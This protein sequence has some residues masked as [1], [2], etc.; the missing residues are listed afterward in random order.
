[1]KKAIYL[2]FF[3][4][5]YFQSTAQKTVPNR[6]YVFDNDVIPRVD[7]LIDPDSLDILLAEGNEFS[8][9]EFPATFIFDNQEEI[10]TVENVG[11]RLR[12]NTSRTSAKKSFKISFNTFQA[13]KKYKGLEKLNL[14]GEHNDPSISRSVIN[15]DILRALKIPGSRAN[16]VNLYLNGNYRGI[17]ANIEH[18]DE[19]FIQKRFEEADGNLYKCLWPSTLEYISSDPNDYKLTSNGR[20]I[21][22]LKTNITTDDYSK[23]S[24]F[25][26]ILN[27]TPNNQLEC[28]LDKVFNVNAYLKAAAFDILIGNWDGPIYNKNNFYLYE[29]PATQKIEYIP[30]DLDNTLGIDWL[31]IDWGN[32][33]IYTWPQ[34][35]EDR[36]IYGR[37]MEND[38]YRDRFSFFIKQMAQEILHPDILFPSIDDLKNKLNPFIAN[39]PFYPLQYGFSTNDFTN[40]FDESL[41]YFQTPYGIKDYIETRLTS[42]LNQL[43][44]NNSSPIITNLVNNYPGLN[45]DIHVQVRVE[46]ESV[47]TGQLFYITN[48]GPTAVPLFDDGQHEDGDANDHIWGCI[49]PGFAE[50][51]TFEY[52]VTFT[53]AENT[54]ARSPVCETK[55][56]RINPT[57]PNLVINEFMASNNSTL[58]DDFGEYDDWIEIYNADIMP[59]FL[60]DFYLTDNLN[61]RNKWKIP[62]LW[63]NPTN[64]LVFWADGDTHQGDQHTNFKLKAAGEQ[65]GIFASRENSFAVVDTLSYDE[66]I[67]DISQGRLP[68]GLGPI[69]FLD[70]PSPGLI[71]ENNTSTNKITRTAHAQFF[72][73]PFYNSIQMSF[74]FE[75]AQTGILYIYNALGQVV[76]EKEFH[77][78]CNR[79]DFN[80]D[81]KDKNSNTS[82]NGIYFISLH[83]S[84]GQKITGSISA[85]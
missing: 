74:T 34:N 33:N 59:I 32:R 23:L 7:I 21:Y 75:L 39:D 3:F 16:H 6:G 58:A 15:W 10:D 80:W 25:I 14:N 64:Y 11:F 56:I 61:N 37:L 42:A 57:T 27:N 22:E 68:N 63:I 52:F 9:H 46:D 43:E 85:Q 55:E 30:F 48:T 82:P 24:E 31:S 70:L 66:Q 20:R 41:N 77:E 47:V 5:L 51:T 79:I 71:N 1:M 18:I 2:L 12:G 54:I 4:F 69:Q 35:L 50:S 26:R 67:S 28:E 8:N 17:F 65:I 38:I 73:N 40:S 19:E 72:P 78:S 81:R 29:N 83:L 62:D 13:G 45:E 49:I 60:G 44:N 76:L 53:D 36:P 84:N